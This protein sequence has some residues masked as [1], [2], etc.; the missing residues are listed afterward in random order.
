MLFPCFCDKTCVNVIELDV[1]YQH[2]ELRFKRLYVN[3]CHFESG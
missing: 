3:K 2:V 1:V